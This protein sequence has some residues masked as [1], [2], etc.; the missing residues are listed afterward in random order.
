MNY[1]DFLSQVPEGKKFVRFKTLPKDIVY[2]MVV[3]DLG[4]FLERD[5]QFMMQN[6]A[7]YKFAIG[8]KSDFGYIQRLIT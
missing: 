7:T 6:R 8:D 3:K 2:E 4:F 1:E 5:T